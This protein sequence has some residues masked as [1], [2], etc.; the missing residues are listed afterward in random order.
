[1][2]KNDLMKEETNEKMKIGGKKTREFLYVHFNTTLIL[3]D[4]L[5]HATHAR[6]SQGLVTLK[7]YTHIYKKNVKKKKKIHK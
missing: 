3:S 1:M 5:H 7:T 4:S 2:P 6:L